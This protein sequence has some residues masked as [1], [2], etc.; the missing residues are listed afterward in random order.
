M[1]ME[2]FKFKSQSNTNNKNQNYIKNRKES[3]E[4]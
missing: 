4:L 1:Y 2:N 3:K